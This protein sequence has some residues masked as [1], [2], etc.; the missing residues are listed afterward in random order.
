MTYS[1]MCAYYIT[2]N[3]LKRKTSWELKILDRLYKCFVCI[4]SI[5]MYSVCKVYSRFLIYMVWVERR[6]GN[7]GYFTCNEFFLKTF[8]TEL[9]SW[10]P[11]CYINTFEYF[12]KVVCLQ[13][14]VD[15]I[16]SRCIFLLSG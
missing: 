5:Y 3:F 1:H 13:A 14:S 10:Q 4:F 9:R 2:P 12:K 7:T 15:R 6:M 11:T 8:A 16:L